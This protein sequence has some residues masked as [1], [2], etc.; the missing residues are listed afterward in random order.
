MTE[1][2]PVVDADKVFG[3]STDYN[4]MAKRLDAWKAAAKVGDLAKLP[5][6]ALA[7]REK[8]MMMAV[9]LMEALSSEQLFAVN[10][11]L[12]ERAK[13]RGTKGN[14]CS[15]PEA[16]PPA[17]TQPS[18]LRVA[19]KKELVVKDDEREQLLDHLKTSSLVRLN[20][21]PISGVGVFAMRTIAKDVDPFTHPNGHHMR[22]EVCLEFSGTEVESLPQPVAEQI[23]SFFAPLTGDDGQTPLRSDDGSLVY[24]VNATGL[25]TLD[26]SW[27]MNHSDKANLYF[28]EATDEHAFCTYRARREI[29]PGE[30]LTIDYRE[31]GREY[32]QHVMSPGERTE[33]PP[34]SPKDRPR[35]EKK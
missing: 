28:L 30:E 16:T 6:G 35:D 34:A 4:N 19:K 10:E 26:L 11:E 22:E 31:L 9:Q 33:S 2:A 15:I 3:G 14:L 17:P 23:R 13:G 7:T 32:Y 25:N 12:L 20:S 27:Y 29:V 8:L 24:G 21:S 1:G 18:D 5:D